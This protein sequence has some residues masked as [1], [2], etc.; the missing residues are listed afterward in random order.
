MIKKYDD[1]VPW[2]CLE[3]MLKNGGE[4]EVTENLELKFVNEK[5]IQ[6]QKDILRFLLRQIGSNLISGKSITNVS[7][8]VDIFEP[9]SL[10]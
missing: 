7:L 5:L 8:P 3:E 6:S 1:Y 2:Y 10:L 4:Y 9:R